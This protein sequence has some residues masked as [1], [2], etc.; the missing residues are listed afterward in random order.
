MKLKHLI[1]SA[2]L[3]SFLLWS[4]GDNKTQKEEVSEEVVNEEEGHDE[5]DH[6]MHDHDADGDEGA[7]ESIFVP[8]GAK[9][10]FANLTDGDLVTSPL[11]IDFGIEGMEV[12]PAGELLEGFGHHHLIIDGAALEAGAIVPADDNNIHYGKG[13]TKAQIELAAGEHTLT[14]QFADGYH[15]SLGE[16]MS[17]TITVTVE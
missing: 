12:G 16:Q 13:Q 2:T 1:L 11:E 10:F 7:L 17:A 3:G 9:V 8:E 5:H 4:C 15:Q 14:M 6:D